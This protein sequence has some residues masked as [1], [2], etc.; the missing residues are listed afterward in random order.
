MA[1]T[2]GKEACMNKNWVLAIFIIFLLIIVTIL[3]I[4]TYQTVYNT[5][6]SNKKQQ[7]QLASMVNLENDILSN[8]ITTSNEEEKISP[9]AI[10]VQKEYFTG[11]DHLIRNEQTIPTDKINFTEEELQIAYPSWTIEEFSNDEV[12]LYR[13]KEGF[14]GEHYLVQENNGILSIY[15]IDENGDRTWKEDTDIQ[16][17]YLTPEDLER[18]TNGIEAVGNEE[19]HSTLEDFE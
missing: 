14:C 2:W 18:V 4:Y 13:E 16:T 15:T 19:L 11:C 5:K 12:V 3:G 8:S 17:M 1:N 7:E 9:D 10:L 6:D